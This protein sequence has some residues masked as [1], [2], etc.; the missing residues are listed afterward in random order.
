MFTNSLLLDYPTGQET[1]DSSLTH[2]S[3]QR[4][5]LNSF[6]NSS[7][8]DTTNTKQFSGGIELD[9]LSEASHTL[10]LQKSAEILS[11]HLDNNRLTSDLCKK[12]DNVTNKFTLRLPTLPN[13]S[14]YYD[15]VEDDCLLLHKNDNTNSSEAD[16]D[17]ITTTIGV[18]RHEDSLNDV[19]SRSSFYVEKEDLPCLDLSVPKFTTSPREDRPQTGLSS[20]VVSSSPTLPHYLSGTI[21][22]EEE[23]LFELLTSDRVSHLSK[24]TWSQIRSKT[25]DDK[26]VQFSIN[27]DRFQG[28]NRIQSQL[29]QAAQVFRELAHLIND[30]QDDINFLDH[31]VVSIKNSTALSVNELQRAS[32]RKRRARRRKFLLVSVAGIISLL[33]YFIYFIPS[34]PSQTNNVLTSGFVPVSP[35][36]P[37]I[38]QPESMHKPPQLSDS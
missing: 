30:Q 11:N 14:H 34:S 38:H 36:Q 8:N 16:T 32:Q 31:S 10:P 19:S 2:P 25:N 29:S 12:C 22:N 20:V 4:Q 18:S 21:Q 26:A 17:G 15:L 9:H 33:I 27:K 6:F 7:L 13:D 23:E 5:G 1:K 37:T 35:T 28:I 3:N 24:N